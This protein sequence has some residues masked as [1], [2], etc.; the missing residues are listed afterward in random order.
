[1][2]GKSGNLMSLI[3]CGMFISFTADTAL[4]GA[5]A[6]PA[7]KRTKYKKMTVKHYINKYTIIKYN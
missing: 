5:A 1:M 4:A 2:E 6:M 3:F 7:W